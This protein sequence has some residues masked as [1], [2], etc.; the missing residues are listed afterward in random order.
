MINRKTHYLRQKMKMLTAML[1][2][3]YLNMVGILQRFISKLNG[4]A[5][6]NYVHLQTVHNMLPCLQ[7]LVTRN[8]QRLH[9]DTCKS[10][11]VFLQKCIEGYHVLR[12]IDMCWAG[13]STYTIITLVPVWVVSMQVCASINE[14]MQ[15]FSSGVS[16]EVS[17]QHKDI[18]AARQTRHA[19]NTID[20][21]DYLRE[22]HSFRM[23]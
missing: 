23:I 20:L 2:L 11:I 17:Y 3:Q 15:T 21:I 9:T 16:Y 19:I 8:I 14:T 18:S 22:I 5:T 13:S 6:G 7:H 10:C 12:R 1:W 4:C